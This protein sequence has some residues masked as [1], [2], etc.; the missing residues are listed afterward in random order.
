M[1]RYNRWVSLTIFSLGAYAVV[2]FVISLCWLYSTWPGNPR[3]YKQFKDLHEEELARVVTQDS[4]GKLQRGQLALSRWYVQGSKEVTAKDRADLN[5]A[6]VLTMELLPMYPSTGQKKSSATNDGVTPSQDNDLNEKCLEPSPVIKSNA[7]EAESYKFPLYPWGDIS[8]V[9]KNV[10]EI[11][12]ERFYLTLLVLEAR[13]KSPC[14][15]CDNE[16]CGPFLQFKN[17]LGWL[18]DCRP[19][20]PSRIDQFGPSEMAVYQDSLSA[21]AAR[22]GGFFYYSKPVD[23]FI[24][25]VSVAVMGCACRVMASLGTYRGHDKFHPRWT[26]FYLLLPVEAAILAAGY[27][28][29]ISGGMW[30][31]PSLNSNA[32][33]ATP[34]TNAPQTFLI[35]SSNTLSLAVQPSSSLTAGESTALLGLCALSFLIGMFTDEATKKLAKIASAIFTDNTAADSFE[36]ANPNITAVSTAPLFSLET[37]A[38]KKDLAARLKAAAT[39]PTKDA[40]EKAGGPD[41][42]ARYIVTQPAFATATAALIQISDPTTLDENDPNLVNLTHKIIN[43]LND[44]IQSEL[45]FETNR[46]AGIE[47]DPVAN[48]LINKNP[49]GTDMVWANWLLL[50]SAYGRKPDLFFNQQTTRWLVDLEGSHIS[51]AASVAVDGAKL[52]IINRV[53]S[54]S[55]NDLKFEY[56]QQTV[57]QSQKIAVVLVN[58]PQAGQTNAKA[59]KTEPVTFTIDASMGQLQLKDAAAAQTP[60]PDQQAKTAEA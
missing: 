52:S 10:I 40:K 39:T 34:G 2:L 9:T 41:L 25:L 37:I 5:A 32:A 43:G 29:I 33:N 54:S 3:A 21:L 20:R 56:Q 26:T 14:P 36:D 51:P 23:F 1:K 18:F 6:I 47:L 15:A 59:L 11:N 24:I 4:I 42:L 53:F 28:L 48:K 17:W 19:H 22:Q 60:P 46:F 50:Q 55:P 57:T 31:V 58:P 8:A 13:Q 45:I 38:N 35:S 27:Y 44:L 16:D 30:S 7:S 12:R 49:S